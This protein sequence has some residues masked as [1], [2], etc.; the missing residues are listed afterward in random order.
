MTDVVDYQLPLGVPGAMAH[1]IGVRRDQ[2]RV[3]EFRGRMIA[4]LFR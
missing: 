1:R 2:E 4:T 3:F